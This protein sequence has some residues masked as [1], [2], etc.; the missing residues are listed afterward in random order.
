MN[1]TASCEIPSMYELLKEAE[2]GNLNL[3]ILSQ[4]CPSVCTLAWGT[5]N[6]D[7]SGIGVREKEREN[8]SLLLHPLHTCQYAISL[9]TNPGKYLLHPTT[10]PHDYLRSDLRRRLW[11]QAAVDQRSR[12]QRRDASPGYPG[13]SSKSTE[14]ICR[15]QRTIQYHC[16]R[17]WGSSDASIT[18][19]I[20]GYFPEISRY[21]SILGP[22]LCFLRQWSCNVE[23]PR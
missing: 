20:R 16:G 4:T 8:C 22:F 3:T 15:R 12:L 9:T 13:I 23:A 5:G 21:R 6:P 11:L 17:G 1:I 14:Y 2:K 10:D 18:T 7:L 19:A